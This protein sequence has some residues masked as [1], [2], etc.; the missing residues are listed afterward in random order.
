MKNNNARLYISKIYKKI[1]SILNDRKPLDDI[2]KIIFENKYKICF[3][4]ILEYIIRNLKI[5][6]HTDYTKG[7]ID[8][9]K[10]YL[11]K[12]N[13][14][15]NIIKSYKKSTLTLINQLNLIY[16]NNN[17]KKNLISEE[18]IKFL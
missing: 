16:K 10:K 6:G 13:T 14:N 15:N 3:K 7:I 4:I 18:N 11:V 2:L 1:D 8:K 17:L 9:I 5:I 12:S